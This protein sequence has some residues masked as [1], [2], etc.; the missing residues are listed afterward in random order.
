MRRALIAALL[1]AAPLP[2]F[3]QVSSDYDAAV[4]A[5]RAGDPAAAE[6][7]LDAWLAAHPGDADALVQRGYARLDQGKRDAAAADFAAVVAAHPDYADARDGLARARRVGEESMPATL[8]I[9]GAYSA[10]PG[11]NDWQEVAA[12]VEVPASSAVRLGGRAAWYRRFGL[13]DVEL[14]A[15]ANWRA[16]PDIW[17]RGWAGGTPKADFRPRKE[18]GAGIDW[19]LSPGVNATVIGFDGSWQQFPAQDVV[20]LNPAI[21][22]YLAG[23]RAAVTVRGIGTIADGGP[24]QVGALVRGDWLP[25]DGQRIFLGAANGPDTDLG[26]VTRTTSLFGGFEIPVSARVSLTGSA[27]HDWRKVGPDRT[28]LRIGVKARL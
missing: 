4:A 2:A 13:E 9:E 6:R 24:L 10:L 7:L 1:L 17:L 22:Q 16:A 12:D 18:A 20:T 8:A 3:A 23:G 28:E 26:I 19:R 15:R 11:A 21:T 27:A 5:R 14:V 25:R